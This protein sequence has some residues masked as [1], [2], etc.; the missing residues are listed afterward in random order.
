MEIP[1]PRITFGNWIPPSNRLASRIRIL[2]NFVRSNLELWFQK[3]KKTWGSN[4]VLTKMKI[5]SF[6]NF[7]SLRFSP[8]LSNML[9]LWR[10]CKFALLSNFKEEIILASLRQDQFEWTPHGNLSDSKVL[11]HSVLFSIN[12]PKFH[13]LNHRPFRNHRLHF[14]WI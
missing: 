12:R 2:K 1:F 9:F 4:W 5:N 14:K 3:G 13:F 10:K 11:N 7:L 8:E 6:T